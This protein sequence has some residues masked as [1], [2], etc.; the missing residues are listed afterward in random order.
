MN[1]PALDAAAFFTG[2]GDAMRGGVPDRDALN[3]FAA[4]WEV[5]FLGPPL[6]A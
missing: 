4:R 1:I 6:T 3:R 2:L 5:E